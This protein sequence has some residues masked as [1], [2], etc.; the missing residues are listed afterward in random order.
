MRHQN[1]L[2]THSTAEWEF[3]IR[4]DS[5]MHMEDRK[6][7][8]T[9]AQTITAAYEVLGDPYQRAQYDKSKQAMVK[10]MVKA[11]ELRSRKLSEWESKPEELVPPEATFA[12]V[13]RRLKDK[14]KK[15]KKRLE[16]ALE[17][18]A[19]KAQEAEARLSRASL[20]RLWN[21]VRLPRRVSPSKDRSRHAETT[22]MVGR[23]GFQ[24]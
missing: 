12:G 4:A 20:T 23:D 1:I 19:H 6:G 10:A 9:E 3:M 22:L 15:S 7:L 17:T 5:M 2:K 14:L 21:Q 24:Q 11:K 16:A 18:S 8:G 13:K